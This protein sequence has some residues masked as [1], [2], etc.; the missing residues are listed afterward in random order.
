MYTATSLG[1]H[2]WLTPVLLSLTSQPYCLEAIKQKRRQYKNPAQVR[3]AQW[4]WVGHY[5]SFPALMRTLVTPPTRYETLLPVQY[6]QQYFFW[7][8][9]VQMHN[10]S[11]LWHVYNLMTSHYIIQFV[12]KCAYS[13][14]RWKQAYKRCHF[15]AVPA[16]IIKPHLFTSLLDSNT[17]TWLLQ[18]SI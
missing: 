16:P 1:V 13:K 7:W 3:H 5:A 2:I 18:Y 9:Y 17:I 12:C 10:R 6:T 8:W 15:C 4:S 14:W 11:W